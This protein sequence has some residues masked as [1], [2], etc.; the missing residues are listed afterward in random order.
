[1][2]SSFLIDLHIEYIQCIYFVHDIKVCCRSSVFILITNCRQWIYYFIW[3]YL[4]RY[5]LSNRYWLEIVLFQYVGDV[6]MCFHFLSMFLH[7]CGFIPVLLGVAI[8]YLWPNFKDMFWTFSMLIR[9][10]VICLACSCNIKML[11]IIHFPFYAY[12]IYAVIHRNTTP[13]YNKSHL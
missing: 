6:H 11:I 9:G 2:Y 12:L 8:S 13:M 10:N 4:G 7:V 3:T 5:I 1:M